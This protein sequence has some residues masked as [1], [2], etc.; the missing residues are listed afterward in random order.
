[1]FI[2]PTDLANAI[3]NKLAVAI[4]NYPEISEEARE[5]LYHQLLDYYD[6]NGVIPDFVVEKKEEK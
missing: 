2:V 1:M 4:Q 6:N 3:K 5:A